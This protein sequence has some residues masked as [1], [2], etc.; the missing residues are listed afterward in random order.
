MPH[1]PQPVP[2]IFQPE[3]AARAIVWAAHHRRREIWVG[4]STM[5]AIIA[6]KIVP[7]F[8]DRYLAA[9]GYDSQQT[10]Q[11]IHAD[12]VDNFWKPVTGDHG[13]HGRF[14]STAQPRSA[15]LFLSTHRRWLGAA[16]AGIGALALYKSSSPLRSSTEGHVDELSY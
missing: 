2:P 7:G 8:I 12:R 9:K 16:L 1:Q 11:R 10:G 15:T 14:D 13:A 4:G 6:N 3:V 5:A